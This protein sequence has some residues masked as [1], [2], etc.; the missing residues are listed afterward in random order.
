M[1]YDS[2]NIAAAYRTLGLTPGVSPLAARR[3]YRELIKESHPD[4]FPHDSA[5]QA[6]AVRATQEINRAYETIKRAAIHHEVPLWRPAP[7]KQPI[8][9]N[10]DY[11]DR[12]T[13]TDRIGTGVLAL[14]L[15]LFLD[16]SIGSELAIVWILV[17]L[18]F[19]VCGFIFGLRAI[20]IVM[21][22]LWWIT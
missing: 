17:P 7:E 13:L 20:E 11:V 15:G 14:L 19:G 9:K 18:I 3:R 4:K 12:S 6:K 1:A 21:R 5:T 2:E 8:S 22:V 16:L 10:V